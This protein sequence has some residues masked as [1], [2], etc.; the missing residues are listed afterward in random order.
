MLEIAFGDTLKP[1]TILCIGAHCDDIEIGCGGALQALIARNPNLTIR[2]VIFGSDPVRGPES[3]AAARRLLA[4]AK[5]EVEQHGFRNSYMPYAGAEVKE[6]FD[7]LRP[8]IEPDL[9]FTHYREDLHQDHRL[10]A[11]LTLNTFRNHAILE[12]EIPKYDGDLGR[13]NLYVPLSREIAAAKIRCLMEC[14]ATQTSRSWFTEETFMALLRLR[15]IECAAESG[16]AEAF[17]AR[18]LVAARL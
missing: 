8:R 6:A 1:R 11:E 10:L 16:L 4:G 12:Y 17:H 14:F 9:V 3:A 5:F 7:Q 2:W 13:P 15:G 18:K